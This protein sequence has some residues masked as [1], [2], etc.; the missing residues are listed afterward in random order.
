[1]DPRDAPSPLLPEHGSCISM[2]ECN[3]I[4]SAYTMYR[5]FE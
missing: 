1:M 4:L 5:H 3:I 2:G